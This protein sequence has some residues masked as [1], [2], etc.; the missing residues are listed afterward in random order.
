MTPAQKYENDQLDI[1]NLTEVDFA[2]DDYMPIAD[3]SVNGDAFKIILNRLL[4]IHQPV[5]GRLTLA[6]GMPVIS[7]DQTAKTTLYFSPYRGGHITLYDGTRW[8]LLA[9]SELSLSLSGYT[10]NKN[11]DIWVYS[12]SGVAALDST[13]WTNDSTRATALASQDG[14]LIK[15]GDATR[16]YLGTIRITGTTG[17]C[18]DSMRRRF[19]WNYYNRR[20]LIGGTWNTNA[21]W[22]YGTAA[23]RESNNG[24]GHARFEFVV[25]VT[26]EAFLRILHGGYN[27][28]AAGIASYNASCFDANNT[29]YTVHYCV[30]ASH[31]LNLGVRYQNPCRYFMAAGYHY[32]TQTEYSG[33]TGTY[34][35]GGSGYP[36]RLANYVVEG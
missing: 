30:G 34:Y 17:Q 10:A 23:W 1:Y 9:F 8:I 16:R 20:R 26:G 3:E 27:A 31:I 18:E 28:A 12:N 25:G 7:S 14:I 22:T 21:S 13:I 11:Y 32:G 19:V 35:D 6:S 5:Q 24:S 4:S 15:S 36:L 29:A 33:A 2:L